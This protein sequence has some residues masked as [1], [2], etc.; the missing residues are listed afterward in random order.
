MDYFSICLNIFCLGA[1]SALHVIFVS[2]LTGKKQKAWNFAVY[3]L[4]LCAFEWIA[5]RIALAWILGI[6]GE[7]LILYG[8]NRLALGNQRSVSWAAAILAIYISQLSFGIVNSV[9]AVI[10]PHLIGMPLI[11][12]LVFLATAAAFGICACCYFAVLKF[13]SLNEKG[14]TSDMA[15]L[16]F[17]VLFFYTAELYIMQTSYTQIV[18]SDSSFAPSIEEL[19]KHM[20]LLFLQVLGLLALLCT[21]YAYRRIC[22]EFQTQAELRSLAQAAGAQKVY[23]GEAKMRYEQTRAFRHDI[24]NHLS[25]LSGLLN[26]GKSEEAKAYLQKLDTVSASMSFPY[27]TGNPVVDILLSEKLGLAKINGIVTEVSLI[28]SNPCEIDDFDLCVIFANALDNAIYAC[29]SIEG[30]KSIRILGERQGDFYMLTF[31]NTC[32]QE[33]SF[34]MGTGLSNIKS[35][36]EKYHGAMMTEKRDQQFCLNVLLNISCYCSPC[37]Q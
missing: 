13:V 19:G 36:A 1:Q 2:R 25:V 31:E 22:R 23:I 24:K 18:Y 26:S 6:G 30:A 28:L 16:L 7:M 12:F 15:L 37:D 10:F 8:I 11:Y 29:Q 21:L 4:I 14:R 32:D 35:V 9:E 34:Q 33:P 27:H 5:A 20:G 17:P 3:L